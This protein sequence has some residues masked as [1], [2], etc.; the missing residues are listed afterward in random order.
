VLDFHA[1]GG[2]GEVYRAQDSELNREVALKRIRAE[3]ADH[4][5]ARQRFLREAEVTAR[6]EHPGVVPVHGLVWLDGQPCYAMRFIQGESLAQASERFHQA[7]QANRDPGERRVALRELLRRFID[8]C[9]TLAYA[10]SRGVLHRDLKPANVMLGP[11]GETLVVDWGLACRFDQD[12]AARE[13]GTESVLPKAPQKAE[14]T[15]QGQVLGTPAYMAPEQAAGRWDAVGPHSDVYGLGATL[16]FLLT[17]QAAFAGSTAEILRQVQRGAFVPPRE[18][19]KGIP[20]ALEAICLKAMALDPA[21]RYTSASVLKEDVEKWLAD[22]LVSAYREPL[23]RQLARWARRHRTRVA[24]GV[25]ALVVAVLLG[26]AG[27]GW[28]LWHAEQRRRIVTADLEQAATFQAK[29]QWAEAR[30]ALERADAVLGAGGPAELRQQLSNA[31]AD[32]SLVDT[33]DRIRLNRAT[34]AKDGFRYA[35]AAEEYEALFRE[36]GL[37]EMKEDA[38]AVA[39]RVAASPVRLALVAALDDWARCA[40]D[41]RQLSWLLEVGRRADPDADGWR[42]RVRDPSLWMN[43]ARLAAVVA[44][45]PVG[46]ASVSLL[47]ALGERLHVLKGDAVGYLRRV[48]QA[49]PGDFWA[50]FSLGLVLQDQDAEEAVGY[51]RA[52]LA[53]RPEAIAVLNNLGNALK[54]KGRVDEAIAS[55][56]EVLRLDPTFAPAFYNLGTA[57][58]AKGQL[59]EAITSY[60]QA[61]HLDPTFALAHTNLGVALQAKGRVNEAIAH[62]QEAL[63]LDPKDAKAHTNLGAAL[64]AKGGVNEAIAHYR[65]AIQIDP[66]LAQTHTNLGNALKAKG[67]LEEAIVHYHQAL[68]LDP[69]LA[70]AHYNLGLALY[71]QGRVEEAIAHY[72]ET[73]QLD[74]KDALAHG[75]LGQALLRQGRFQ[76]AREALRRCLALLPS[77]SA[78]CTG[79]SRRLQQC[80]RFLELEGRLPAV[81]QGNDKP[82]PTQRLHFADFC[83][84]TKRYASATRLFSAALAE[85]PQLAENRQAQHRYNAACAAALA[86]A[87]QGSDAATLTAQERETLRRQALDWLRAELAVWSGT[88]DRAVIERTLTHW[89]RDTDLASLREKEA[90]AKLP[91]AEREAWQKLWAD[92]AGLLK[93][94]GG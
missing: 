93:K 40:G 41:K 38:A 84:R 43:R 19:K 42:K 46:G 20:P 8:V 77:D 12:A 53:L 49:H 47:V 1:R 26:G 92:V 78:L 83:V 3:Y 66:K 37:G 81:L 24:A 79:I 54:A 27:L 7:D 76:Q 91:Q 58:K 16:Y 36:A 18:R 64:Q 71:D 68:Q 74:P 80:E 73:L 67:Q 88:S 57:L 75:A 94:S 59:D 82:E 15:Q 44:E 35:E 62:F 21:E 2:L 90:L 17:G 65:L 63:L 50:N 89:Q 55:Y 9:N 51:Y 13:Q 14:G 25:T 4:D 10:H 32:L 28:Q 52:A 39:A 11:F 6:L 31:Q 60:K 61:L 23:R 45:A 56:K 34:W 33:L 85:Q 69:G 86:A 22:E 30:A 72:Q 87:A 48:Q 70:P 29:A 5:E